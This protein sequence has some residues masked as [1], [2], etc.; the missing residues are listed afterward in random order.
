M[1]KNKRNFIISAAL[2]VLFILF[3]VLVRVVDVRPIGPL[4]SSVGFAGLNR[5]VQQALGSHPFMYTVTELLG[6]VS[7]LVA[8]GMG[9]WTLAQAIRRKS[10]KKV[11][12]SLLCLM[13]SYVLMGIF[14]VMFEEVIVNYRPILEE[15]VLEASYPSSHTLLVFTIIGTALVRW[16]ARVSSRG[17][18]LS[19]NILGV[20][21]IA[22]TVVGRLLSGVHWFTDI[23]GGVLLSLALVVFYYSLHQWSKEG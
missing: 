23:L 15:G 10:I 17:L 13:A 1:S 16:N 4:D 22:V 14:Y 18:K 11:D 19:G 7:L 5:A 9:V 2:W 6:V 21:I 3:T 20:A 8:G 12:R